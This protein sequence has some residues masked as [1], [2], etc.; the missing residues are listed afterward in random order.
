MPFRGVLAI[1]D[2]GRSTM[3]LAQCQ[4]LLERVSKEPSESLE[5][6]V[7]EFKHYSS[8]A[9]LHNAKDLAE[10]ISAFANYKGGIIVIGVR[11]SSSVPHGMWRDQLA[12]MVKV[13]LHTTR[14]RLRGK[15]KP[16]LE[17][18]LSVLPYEGNSYLLI[19]VPRRRDSLVS[20]TSGKVC[21]RDGKSSRP[22]TPDEIERAV[23]NLQD[24]DWSAECLDANPDSV[25]NES[26]VQEARDDFLN[27]RNV[28][29]VDKAGFLE[30]IGV[31]HNGVVTK[32][33]L[34]FLGETDAIRHFLGK[35]EFRFS[36]KT[37]SGVLLVND[38]WEGCLW[39]TIKRAKAHFE[40]CNRDLPFNFQAKQYSVQLLDRIAF[41]EAYLNALVHRDYAEDGM[42][43]VNF[44]ADRLVITSPG[45]FYGGVTADNIAKH[46]PRHRNKA[47]ARML[48][49]YHLVD[50]A[51]MGVL[52]MSVNSLRYGRAFPSFAEQGDCVEVTMQGEYFRPGIFVLAAQ[53]GADYGVP[54]LLIL[55]SVYEIGAV[56]VH[57]LAKQ[58]AKAVDT[59]WDAIEQAAQKLPSVELC[60]TRS[61]IFI[62]CRPEWAKLLDVTKVFRV[63]SASQRHVKLYRFLLRHGRASNAD[64]KAHLGFKQTSQTS[65]F[66]KSAS[67]VRRSGRGPSSVWELVD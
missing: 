17:L 36:R 18:E 21:I 4:Q 30:A 13:D 28:G 15:L 47:L 56:P 40:Q 34:L 53:E 52:R 14:E 54:E 29:V 10:E 25:L 42:V 11:D 48:M 3:N 8:E 19:Y 50:R 20:T 59:P 35:H 44:T 27:R 33:G 12:G 9:A 65:V 39:E 61:G 7:L 64:I 1:Q 2:I 41:H 31:T 16:Y 51:G 62:R 60:G 22:M 67:Y 24:Y 57:S 37:A 43:S 45:T 46:E 58:L 6:D 38:V 5:S 63:T 32:S 55:N 23:K 26:A 66:L 49:E